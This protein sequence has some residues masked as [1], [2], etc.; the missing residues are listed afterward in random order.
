MQL[1]HELSLF[2]EETQM[3]AENLAK[4]ISPNL[5]WKE[6]VSIDDMSQVDDALKGV[7]LA[8]IMIVHYQ[9]I[10]TK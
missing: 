1:M 9:K 6:V 2:P 5:I 4:I 3:T 8:N 7:Q 10:F